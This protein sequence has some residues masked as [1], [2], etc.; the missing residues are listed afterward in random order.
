MFSSGD[1]EYGGVRREH[2]RVAARRRERHADCALRARGRRR[3]VTTDVSVEGSR[4]GRRA[5]RSAV[6]VVEVRWPAFRRKRY[7]FGPI[8][9]HKAPAAKKGEA[10]ESA[11]IGLD[12]AG[13]RE[14]A[15]DLSD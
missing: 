4:E 6:A 3:P 11:G 5:R 7:L 12:G 13:G 8:A 9:W 14:R 1:C 10:T 2:V 15:V